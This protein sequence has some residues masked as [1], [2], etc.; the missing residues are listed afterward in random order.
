MGGIRN[1]TAER[2]RPS[3]D[4][5]PPSATAPRTCPLRSCRGAV[6]GTVFCSGSS[7][8]AKRRRECLLH[9]EPGFRPSVPELLSSYLVFFFVMGFVDFNTAKEFMDWVI[10]RRQLHSTSHHLHNT[11]GIQKYRGS[12]SGTEFYFSR[13][14]DIGRIF[15]VLYDAT[16]EGQSVDLVY[17]Y[18]FL[19]GLLRRPDLGRHG[20]DKRYHSMGGTT[21]FASSFFLLQSQ[22]SGC[23][24]IEDGNHVGI[25]KRRPSG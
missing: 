16:G 20:V 7:A 4:W 11:R 2:A 18:L 12:W 17:C 25:E 1:G 5:L 13:V 6:R 15:V 21:G 23:V 9:A 22:L 24:H 14:D 10:R 8:S 3:L 19:R